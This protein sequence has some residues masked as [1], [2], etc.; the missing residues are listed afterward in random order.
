MTIQTPTNL[1]FSFEIARQIKSDSCGLVFGINTFLALAF[2]TILTLIVVE[3]LQLNPQ[4][5]FVIYGLYSFAI[6]L[7]LLVI[8]ITNGFRKG[9]KPYLEEIK[10][11]GIWVQTKE[12]IEEDCESKQLSL[13]GAVEAT[14]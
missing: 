13:G 4:K 2:Q 3:I 6:A 14:K 12:G 8:F 10:K 5:Q 1:Y 7:L 9:W 11:N